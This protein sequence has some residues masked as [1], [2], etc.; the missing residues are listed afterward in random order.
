MHP[1]LEISDVTSII[2]SFL[3]EAKSKKTLSSLA[4]TC[5]DLKEPALDALYYEVNLVEAVM[6]LPRDVW[7]TEQRQTPRREAGWPPQ[8][9][10]CLQRSIMPSDWHILERYTN[11]VQS[12]RIFSMSS[13]DPVQAVAPGFFGAISIYCGASLFPQLRRLWFGGDRHGQIDLAFS[14]FSRLLLGPRLDNLQM[15]YLNQ[16]SLHVLKAVYETSQELQTLFMTEICG[17][18]TMLPAFLLQAAEN[19][20]NLKTLTF[21]LPHVDVSTRVELLSAIGQFKSLRSLDLFSPT[22]DVTQ[23]HDFTVSATISLPNLSHIG[24]G[25]RNWALFETL[26]NCFDIKAIPSF[27]VKAYGPPDGNGNLVFTT[28]GS[29]LP[30]STRNI[31]VS[32][33]DCTKLDTAALHMLAK[34]SDLTSLDVDL[35]R[36]TFVLANDDLRLLAMAV[37]H[38]LR[39]KFRLFPRDPRLTLRGVGFLLQSCTKLKY[40]DLA[41]DLKAANNVSID[42]LPVNACSVT[43][44]SWD[45][46]YSLIDDPEFAARHLSTMMPYLTEIKD[47]DNRQAWKKVESLLAF[48]RGAFWRHQQALRNSAS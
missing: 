23:P 7:T 17:D 5:K 27:S 1:S 48:F 18:D 15:Y 37:P 46:S 31:R 25:A 29:R 10:L 45:V 19:M 42:T 43:L 8:K 30:E 41:V 47:W 38:I 22:Q 39:L 36:S 28:L 24:L 2:C 35:R 9:T 32:L 12:L 6:C 40:L 14:S 33:S 26:M 21:S 44:I 34:F 16:N 20:K 4:R 13:A 11:R 3:A